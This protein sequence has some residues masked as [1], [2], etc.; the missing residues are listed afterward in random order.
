[1]TS[2]TVVLPINGTVTIDGVLFEQGVRPLHVNGG[3]H[4]IFV[5]G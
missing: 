5:Q 3:N 2:G 1:M 4:S